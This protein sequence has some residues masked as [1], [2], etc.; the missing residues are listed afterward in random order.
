M[1]KCDDEE[2]LPPAGLGKHHHIAWP[3]TQGVHVAGHAGIEPTHVA[4]WAN[5]VDQ[6]CFTFQVYET[7][8]ICA[9]RSMEIHSKKYG[10]R[11]LFVYLL[12]QKVLRFRCECFFDIEKTNRLF[13]H[14][15]RDSLIA[16]RQS[17]IGQTSTA[18]VVISRKC[19]P[20][21]CPGLLHC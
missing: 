17:R 13:D 8:P 14:S 12:V 21:P 4:H 19:W 10:H 5:Q 20:L 7:S 3:V 9:D 6:R 18:F 11:G 2:S 16:K 15:S 1:D